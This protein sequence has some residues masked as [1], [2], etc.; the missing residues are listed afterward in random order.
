M[1]T[2]TRWPES[3]HGSKKLES[4]EV[5]V[6]RFRR[7]LLRLR[8]LHDDVTLEQLHTDQYYEFGDFVEASYRVT[9][10]EI[11]GKIAIIEMESIGS[12]KDPNTDER[13]PVRITK[14]IY[15]E[16]KNK[17]IIEKLT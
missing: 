6:D 2:I 13:N 5:L 8:F 15:I 7:S 14:D 17:I 1:N 9:S 11:E 10:S 12:I 3:Y 16:G 4:K